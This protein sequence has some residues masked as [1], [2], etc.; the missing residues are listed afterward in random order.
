MNHQLEYLW[1]NWDIVILGY[2]FQ[3]REARI[4]IEELTDK[5]SGLKNRLEK[6]KKEKVAAYK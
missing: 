4:Q 5:N 3:L 1:I 2:Y 6:M